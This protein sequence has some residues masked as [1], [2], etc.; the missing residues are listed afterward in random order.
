MH[1]SVAS[2]GVLLLDSAPK[3]NF[4][5]PFFWIASTPHLQFAHPHPW[6][7]IPIDRDFDVTRGVFL[8]L[9]RLIPP[10]HSIVVACAA[11]HLRLLPPCAVLV[12]EGL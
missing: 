5:A 9:G 10:L 3:T 1:L 12:G 4:R 2:H 7:W 6:T 11:L 8:V